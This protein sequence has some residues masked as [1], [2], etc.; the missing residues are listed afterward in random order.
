MRCPDCNKFVSY[1]EPQCEVQDVDISETTLLATV[2]IALNCQDCG[3]TLKD[4]EVEDE[5]E[6]KHTCKPEKDRP[7]NWRESADF[8]EGEQFEVEEQ[9]EPEP[10]DRLENRDRHGKAIKNPRYMK[11]FYGFSLESDVRCRKCGEVFQVPTSGEEQA[12]AFNEC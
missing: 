5:T 12:S 10:N 11:R 9:G 6:I 8:D 2:A 3:T 7:E 4:A 1:D